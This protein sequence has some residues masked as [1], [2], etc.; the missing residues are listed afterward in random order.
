MNTTH[1]QSILAVKALLFSGLLIFCASARAQEPAG[2]KEIIKIDLHTAIEKALESSE[3]LLISRNNIEKSET[4][5]KKEKS[6]IYPQV[7]GT[8]KVTHHFEYPAA[9]QG[10]QDYSGDVGV[11]LDQLLW[12]FGKV[13]AA[14]NASDKYMDV[15]RL[16]ADTARQAVVYNTKVSYFSVKLAER[17]YAILLQSLHNAQDNK[18]ILEDRSAS[19]RV[20]RRDFLK[21]SADVAARQPLV[22]DAEKTRHTAHQEFKVMIGLDA[23]TDVFLSEEFEKD[24]KELD[25]VKMFEA[26]RS[27]EPALKALSREV[28]LREDLIDVKKASF[29]PEVSGFATWNHQG[30]DQDPDWG[31]PNMDDYGTVGVKVSVPIWT[32]GFLTNDLQSA[33]IQKR[34]SELGLRKAQENY[35]LALDQAMAS[36]HDLIKTLESNNEAVRLAEESF[37]L[38]QDFFKTGS[39]TLTDLNDAELQLTQ[40][41]LIRERTLYNICIALAK[42]EQ[43][44]LREDLL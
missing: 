43:L 4:D 5:Y 7:D 32:G 41:R 6:V 37:H 17:S 23:S 14:I 39:A 38:T 25:A 34:N 10:T 20:S 18:K 13:R 15:A 29:L 33:R 3:D 35:G 19:G 21:A 24:H 26:M 44:T 31:S 2:V 36:Y 42:I 30:E 1:S 16:N 12:S 27:N 28:E 22:N 11:S 9:A 8:G 40:Q